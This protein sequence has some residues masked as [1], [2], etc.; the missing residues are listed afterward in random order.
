MEQEV[1]NQPSSHLK[2]PKSDDVKNLESDKIKDDSNTKNKDLDE[3]KE[4]KD[5]WTVLKSRLTKKE[6]EKEESN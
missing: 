6:E 1:L 2:S 5:I 3:D 4:D